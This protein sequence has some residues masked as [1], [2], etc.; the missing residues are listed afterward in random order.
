MLIS[1][2]GAAPHRRCQGIGTWGRGP[3]FEGWVS[4]D[5]GGGGLR[6]LEHGRAPDA[7]PVAVLRTPGRMPAALPPCGGRRQVALASPRRG[8]PAPFGST[9]Y[10][11]D[12]T[13]Y[14]VASETMKVKQNVV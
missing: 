14:R 3:C 8:L 4:A 7:A 6:P 5:R 11:V 9:S 10:V 12:S 13:I 1:Q 2:V